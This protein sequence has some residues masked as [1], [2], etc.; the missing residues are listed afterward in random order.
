MVNT[1]CAIEG[2]HRLPDRRAIILTD[3]SDAT[4]VVDVV[5]GCRDVGRRVMSGG[6][7]VSL[8]GS[9]VRARC[10]GNGAA[11]RALRGLSMTAAS[12]RR[13]NVQHSPNLSVQVDGHVLVPAAGEAVR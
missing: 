3:G 1:Y 12:S 10:A 2:S 9:V 5:A 11:P 7:R 8:A 4:R 13:H 6:A